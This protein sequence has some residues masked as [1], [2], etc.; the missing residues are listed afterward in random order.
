MAPIKTCVLGSGLSGMTFQI[1][2]VLALSDLFTLH[3]VLERSASTEG[4]RVKE[5]FGIIPKIHKTLDDVLADDDVELVIIS[6]PNATHFEYAKLSLEA[7]KHVLVEKP[8]APTVSEAKILGEIAKSK[9]L[10]LYAF[11]NR[12]W[13]SD[14]LALKSLLSQPSNSNLSIGDLVEFETQQVI[15]TYLLCYEML[16]SSQL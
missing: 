2:F 6:T 16:I 9:K 1:P 10:V 15:F 3:A 4:G 7:G 13:D 5:R 8:V 11:Q 12:R 14:F